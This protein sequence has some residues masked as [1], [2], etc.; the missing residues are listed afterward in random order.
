M[1]KGQVFG[2]KATFA[3]PTTRTINIDELCL[4]S[5]LLFGIHID[6]LCYGL[7]SIGT[8][9]IQKAL[10]KRAETFVIHLV[11]NVSSV[12]PSSLKPVHTQYAEPDAT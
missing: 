3:M 5:L 10:L 9:A 11:V 1:I 7:S 8:S 4:L 6:F 2:G 12:L